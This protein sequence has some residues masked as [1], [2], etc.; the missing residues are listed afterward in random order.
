MLYRVKV[1]LNE[2][3]ALD[4]IKIYVCRMAKPI[5]DFH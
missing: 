5:N 3:F 4:K 2:F 1:F